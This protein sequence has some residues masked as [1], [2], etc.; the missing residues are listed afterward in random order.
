MY[1]ERIFQGKHAEAQPLFERV[2][3]IND[4]ALGADHPDTI[5]SRAWMGKLYMEQGFFDKASALLE[6]VVSARERVQGH[7]HPDVANALGNWAVLLR[8]QVRPLKLSATCHHR[9]VFGV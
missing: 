1:L 8:S 2:L 4:F 5:T 7:D 9:N 3:A 6:E